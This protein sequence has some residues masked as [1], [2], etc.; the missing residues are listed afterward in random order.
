MYAVYK[1][2][3]PIYTIFLGNVGLHTHTRTQHN[4]ESD[5]YKVGISKLP[6]Q[7]LLGADHN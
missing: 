7:R 6:Q 4:E 3:G 2:I 5:G 1:I